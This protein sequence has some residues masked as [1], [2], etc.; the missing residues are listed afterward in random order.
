MMY[1]LLHL[2]EEARISMVT[3]LP[4]LMEE[5]LKKFI[6]YLNSIH[7]TGKKTRP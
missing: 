6:L 5:E 1:D 3:F 7:K 4:G 2:L